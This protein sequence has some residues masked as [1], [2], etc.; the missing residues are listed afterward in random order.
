MGIKSSG[1]FNQGS[2]LKMNRKPKG[3]GRMDKKPHLYSIK[4]NPYIHTS[5]Y[6]TAKQVNRLFQAGENAY[7]LACPLNRFITI[8]YDDYA[9]RKRPQRFITGF[10]EHSRKWLKR[11]GLP[12]AYLYTLENGK[13]KGIH[14]HLL[15]HIPAG[16]Q[17]AYKKAMRGW[18]P[19]EV[20][21]PRVKFKTIQYPHF[22]DLSPL[23]GVYGTLRYMCKGIDPKEP[24]RDITPIKQGEIMGRR[25]GVSKII[26]N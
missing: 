15:I 19:F 7:R 10:L 22:G 9:D 24:V 25:W 20:K 5:H 8:H 26:R 18:L 1:N 12:I 4:K 11:R 14:A 17:V 21:T 13:D 23:H 16:Y 2:N 6:L 3:L